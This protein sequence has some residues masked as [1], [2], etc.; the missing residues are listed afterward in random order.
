M[1]GRRGF[2]LGLAA[3]PVATVCEGQA[4]LRCYMETTLRRNAA[5][6]NECAG[7]RLKDVARNQIGVTTS[8]DPAYISLDYPN[9]DFDRS[10]GVC[11]DVIIR[12][13]RDAFKFDLQE[14]IH[15][16][17]RD[18]FADYPSIWGLSQPDKNIDHRRVP[19][20]ETF[21]ERGGYELPTDEW[22]RGDLITCRVG[23]LP[24]IGIVSGSRTRISEMGGG[25]FPKVIHNIGRG[26][27][28]E[29]VIGLYNNERRFRFLPAA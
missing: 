12:A 24:H 3:T 22:A 19:N 20:I 18:N 8:Y 16:D 11:T 15:E 27:R 9:G 13:Y 6:R 21:L 4:G 10:S 7:V 14:A 5:Y 2:L 29:S 23:N 26:T 17:M 1:I 28:E 25:G